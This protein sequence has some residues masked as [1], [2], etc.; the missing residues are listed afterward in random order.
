MINR[1]IMCSL[2]KE[3]PTV[4]DAGLGKTVLLRQ[5]GE[6]SCGMRW[7]KVSLNLAV[8]MDAVCSSCCFLEGAW[9]LPPWLKVFI[10]Y[11]L[12]HGNFSDEEHIDG[13]LSLCGSLQDCAT[14][15][16]KQAAVVFA[17]GERKVSWESQGWVFF[18]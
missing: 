15:T 13:L 14:I 10:L 17:G 2:V 6:W 12:V 5:V 7:E 8:G 18:D 11:L 4:E 3:E 1:V 16:L 9:T